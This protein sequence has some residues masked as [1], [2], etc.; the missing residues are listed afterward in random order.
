[1][2]F[3]F[4][5][6]VICSNM[7]EFLM[8]RFVWLVNFEWTILASSM[9]VYCISDMFEFLDGYGRELHLLYEPYGRMFCGFSWAP[10][11]DA[12]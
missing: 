6:W 1:M 2:L 9:L 7:R 11:L 3:L 5:R 8:M 10:N 12:T 4:S